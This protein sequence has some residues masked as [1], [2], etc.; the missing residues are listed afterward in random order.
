MKKANL[1]SMV[2][3][4]FVGNFEPSVLKTNEVEVGVKKY[5]MGDCEGAH[6]H[7]IATEV[8]VILSGQVRMFDQI[9]SAGDIVT[10]DPG[11][12]TD[13]L[14]LTDAVTV[15]VKCPGAK[16]DKYIAGPSLC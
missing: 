12:T 1:E 8:T 5:K 10:I 11:E 13:F 2:K 7:K 6:F 4:W 3:G 16:N 14:A 15:V 9:F